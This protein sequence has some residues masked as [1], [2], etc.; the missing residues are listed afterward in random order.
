[1]TTGSFVQIIPLVGDNTKPISD[2]YTK[3]K[4][5][6]TEYRGKPLKSY[7]D[8]FLEKTKEGDS[9]R[10]I[11][12]KGRAGIGKSAL[13]DKMAFDWA[14]GNQ[15][16][17]EYKLVFILKMF[18]LEDS[19][20]LIDAIFHQLI[21][22]D[23]DIN[24][25]D[26][27]SYITGNPA[28]V[29][30]L[31]DGFDEFKTTNVSEA[32]SSSGNIYQILNRK[33]LGESCVVVTTRHSHFHKLVGKSLIGKPF[34]KV[35]VL[36]FT[37]QEIKQYIGEFFSREH[38]RA[39]GLI[40]RIKS[41][42]DLFDLAT[43]PLLLLLMCLVWREQST[44][45]DTM[46]R[47]YKDALGYMFKRNRLPPDEASQVVTKVGKNALDDLL[48]PHQFLSFKEGDFEDGALRSALKAG[49]LTSQR[50]VRGLDTRHSV[51]FNH[52]TF[53]E[54]CAAIFFQ[55]LLQTDKEQFN[56][57]LDRV[58]NVMRNGSQSLEYFLRF[59]CGDNQFCTNKVLS[60]IQK[61]QRSTFEEELSLKCYF[62]GQFADLPSVDLVSEDMMI[63]GYSNDG[64]RALL[65]YLKRVNADDKK[66]GRRNTKFKKVTSLLISKSD[67]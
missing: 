25:D 39:E 15:K 12:L 24:R 35:Q 56:T 28:K 10:R 3:L 50:V 2:I 8:I 32:S 7:E 26:L 6:Y 19:K 29:L 48:S 58:E 5:Q 37:E 20:E 34:V 18:A 44:I 14:T 38:D 49:V 36:G 27:W 57:N 17:Q 64:L 46:F 42:D 63:E 23:Q 47:L 11:V 66:Q 67:W 30:I 43:S 65:Y 45:P 33:V 13:V 51:C 9:I 41:S 52:R 62:E 54:Y 53:Q 21:D 22:E 4:L 59:C 1:M 55:R 16:L 60:L 31:F 40:R 61:C